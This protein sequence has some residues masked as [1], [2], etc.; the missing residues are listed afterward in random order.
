MIFTCA[1]NVMSHHHTTY[2]PQLA[3]TRTYLIQNTRNNPQVFLCSCVGRRHGIKSKVGQQGVATPAQFRCGCSRERVS[4]LVLGVVSNSPY[5]KQDS[6]FFREGFGH[7]AWRVGQWC[8]GNVR[9]TVWEWCSTVAGNVTVL[10][11]CRRFT[12]ERL[13]EHEIT[14]LPH[15]VP[16]NRTTPHAHSP[17]PLCETAAWTPRSRALQICTHATKR[18]G[19]VLMGLG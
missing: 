8:E 13:R 19:S 15:N 1:S 9:A 6:L 14:K 3:S 4:H 18:L 10:A 12:S 5:H 11:C 16:R 17:F 7:E 2:R